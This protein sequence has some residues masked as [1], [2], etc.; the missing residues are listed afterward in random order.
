MPRDD[1]RP[2]KSI[3]ARLRPHRGLPFGQRA[4][5]SLG[6]RHRI[7]RGGGDAVLRF[8]VGKSV[9]PRH[10]ARRSVA[11]DG[12]LP[13]RIPRSRRED[14]HSVPHQPDH[15]PRFSRR[16]LHDQVHRRNA[17][18]VPFHGAPRSG[19]EAVAVSRR[20][21]R[22]RQFARERSPEEHAP[23][24][25][26]SSGVRSKKTGSRRLAAKAAKA[27]RREIRRLGAGSKSRC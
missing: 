11:A 24:T 16:Q 26:T 17:G 19:H 8:T 6:R 7:L 15:A 14:E 5:H 2:G 21:A 12:A 22:Q 13:A 1:R 27:R 23:R 10:E 20:S 9:G 25:G 4:G 18:I 3:R